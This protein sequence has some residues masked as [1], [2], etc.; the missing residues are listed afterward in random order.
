MSKLAINGGP[1]ACDRQW[2][3]WPIHDHREREALLEVLDSGRWFYSEKVSQ[4]EDAYAKFQGANFGVTATSGTTALEIGL[5]GVGVGPGDEVII[6]PYTFIATASS[7]MKVNAVPVFADIQPRTACLDPDDVERKI[8]DRTKAIMPVHLAGCMAD[9]D[10]LREIA[11]KHNLAIVEDACH[12][13]GSQWRGKGAGAVGDCGAF[14]F[15]VSKNITAGEGGIIVTD[16]EELADVCRSYSNC[17][18]S[19]GGPWYSHVRVGSNLRM[20]EFQAALLLAQLTRLEDHTLR[21]MANADILTAGLR[22][23]PGIIVFENDP[24]MTRRSYHMYVFRV[25]SGVL[26][27]S[28]EQF[29]TAIAA[30]GVPAGAGYGDPLYNNAMFDQP[31][32]ARP[33]HGGRKIDYSKVSCPVCE[34]ICRD[35]MWISHQALLGSEMDMHAIVQAITKVVENIKEVQ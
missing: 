24:R 2:I 23:L 35:T 25:D 26:G 12:A 20:T 19:K 14:S 9:M 21:R 4:F 11:E 18:R 22:D 17:G 27:V 16:S 32:D 30:E 31:E 28:R 8:T 5:L 33:H 34:A 6:P 1:R 29:A 13:W 15:Q 10:H 3:E 7:V